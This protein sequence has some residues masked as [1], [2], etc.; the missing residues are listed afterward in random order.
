M[1]SERTVGGIVMGTGGTRACTL[2]AGSV[3]EATTGVK[4]SGE[5]RGIGCA[6]GVTFHRQ[7]DN[8]LQCHEACGDTD[9]RVEELPPREG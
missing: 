5:S 7:Q 6:R 1:Q 3:C 9:T 4:G 2:L 8:T